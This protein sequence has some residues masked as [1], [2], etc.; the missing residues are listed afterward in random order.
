MTTSE[1]GALTL[2]STSAD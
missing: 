1:R 2:P